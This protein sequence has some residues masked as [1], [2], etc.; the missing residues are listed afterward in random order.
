MPAEIEARKTMDKRKS[1]VINQK[2]SS[3]LNSFV[4]SPVTSTKSNS[5]EKHVKFPG[6]QFSGYHPLPE[7]KQEPIIITENSNH[8]EMV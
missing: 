4:I 8:N 1:V 6:N 3:K 7:K 5:P 2:Y